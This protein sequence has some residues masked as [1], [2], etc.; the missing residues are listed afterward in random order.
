MGNGQMLQ[1]LLAIIL[2]STTLITIYNSL[3]D[4]AEFVYRGIY[5]SQGQKIVDKYLMKF[6]SELLGEVY[7]Y[8][9][10]Y[11]DYHDT[12]TTMDVNNITYNIHITTVFCDSTGS[13]HYP[14]SSYE[15]YQKVNLSVWCKPI[16]TDTLHIGTETHPIC[17]VFKDL[18]I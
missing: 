11:A 17:E 18:Q 3:H 10:I 15:P 12:T 13:V 6:E 16:I 14:Y 5:Q 4:Q 7:D 9:E 1:I 2:F 8:L